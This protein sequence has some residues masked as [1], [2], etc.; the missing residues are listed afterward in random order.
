MSTSLYFARAEELA[1]ATPWVDG[2]VLVSCSFGSWAVERY[3]R[4]RD[5][6]AASAQLWCSWVLFR[7]DGASYEEVAC[8][9]FAEFGV[10]HARIRTYVD[11]KMAAVKR[12]ARD[13]SRG[14][15][16]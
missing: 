1:R 4:S 11:E 8:G 2:Y 7:E 14:V 16:R 3:P 10:A 5:A 12:E 15:L 6:H 9:G 13:A